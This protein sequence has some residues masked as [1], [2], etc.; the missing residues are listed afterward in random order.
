[1]MKKNILIFL[2]LFAT[3]MAISGCTPNE[4]IENEE[5]IESFSYEEHYNLS[6]IRQEEGFKNTTETSISTKEQAIN[7]AQKELTIEYNQTDVFYDKECDMYMVSFY[8]EGMLG[9]GQDVYMDSKGITKLIIYS[10]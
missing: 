8:T 3:L 5:T 10:E 7:V 2:S 6:A 1:M 9:G 4:T